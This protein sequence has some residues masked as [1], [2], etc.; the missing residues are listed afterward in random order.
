MH[1]LHNTWVLRMCR[2]KSQRHLAGWG[3]ALAIGLVFAGANTRYI[4]NFVSG[5]FALSPADLAQIADPEAAPRYFAQ[6]SGTQVYDT[7]VQQI[8][9]RSRHGK[10]V[11][12]EVSAGYYALEVGQKLLIVKSASGQPTQVE[13]ELAAIPADLD[14]Q[15]FSTPDMEA[16]RASF[17]PFY[18]DAESFR[19]PGYWG[20]G[21]GLVFL[22]LFAVSLHEFWPR[23][24]N[25]SVSPTAVRVAG[26]GDPIMLSAEIEREFRDSRAHR[27]GKWTLTDRYVIM[28][29][30]FGFDIFRLA[31]LLWA[32]K[33]V[34]K[35]STNFIPT[36]KDYSVVLICYG[37][38]AEI[39][40]S[41]KKVD[42]L[43]QETAQ[44]APWA[45]F[46]YS[47]ELETAFTKHQRDFC[48]AVEARRQELASQ[49]Q[50][51]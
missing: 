42:A 28:S 51:G 41:Q 13:G 21:I 29:S 47:Q 49:A 43:L 3:V 8:T 33:K 31:D 2:Q 6:V 5:P 1:T 18:L 50:P 46:G 19:T 40:G 44:R 10:E 11:S 24:R 14:R 37:G 39:P 30:F 45:F 4:H 15:I 23:Y 38:Q 35:K 7:G 25:P 36:G 27:V 22:G 34:L 20:I 26:W 9:V 48:L 16:V 17:Y 12:R 32:Y